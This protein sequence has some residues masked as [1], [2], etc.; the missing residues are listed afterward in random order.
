ML[1]FHLRRADGESRDVPAWPS[2]AGDKP[3]LDWTAARR[4]NNGDGGGRLLGRKNAGRARG[5]D[6][7]H[8]E[9]NQLDRQAWE[10]TVISFCP[11]VFDGD[12]LAL[13]MAQIAE[14][15]SECV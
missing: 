9:V 7:I 6:Y 14:R 8:F 2:V 1:R 10:P 11:S 15:L 13:N 4:K 12:V 3:A 5:H